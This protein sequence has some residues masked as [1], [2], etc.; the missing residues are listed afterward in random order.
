MGNLVVDTTDYSDDILK[1][2]FDILK[3]KLLSSFL[4]VMVGVVRTE[5]ELRRNK[6]SGNRKHVRI[7]TW[8][9]SIN[10]VEVVRT[11]ICACTYFVR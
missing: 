8:N 9:V 4:H 3:K 6:F 10:P 2:C 1:S 7:L 5:K 11:L